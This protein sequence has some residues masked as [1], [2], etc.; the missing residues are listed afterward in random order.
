MYNFHSSNKR[1]HPSIFISKI[2]DIDLQNRQGFVL[3]FSVLVSSLLLAIGLAVFNIGQK[4]LILSATARD[5]QFAFYAADTG[6]ECA[7]Y[8]DFQSG[9]FAPGATPGITC[10]GVSLP[11]VGGKDYGVED[12]FRLDL[13]PQPYCV[14]V[15]VR[16][17]E[18]PRRTYVKARGYNTCDSSNP[19]R[20]ERAIRATY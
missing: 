10:S 20:V 13:S 7:F 6:I 5:S 15:T 1:G 8:W 19:R 16:K 9:T 18:A 14:D 4:E 17:T 11:N 3:L 12:T 2:F